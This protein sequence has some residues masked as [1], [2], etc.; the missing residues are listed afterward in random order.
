M[1]EEVGNDY[2]NLSE[3]KQQVQ[4]KKKVIKKPKE[5]NSQGYVSNSSDIRMGFN[6]KPQKFKSMR[7]KEQEE[8]DEILKNELRDDE[9]ISSPMQDV[10]NNS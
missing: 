9:S 3:K 4:P 8:E 1:E 10:Y 2:D 7:T 6:A 5:Q